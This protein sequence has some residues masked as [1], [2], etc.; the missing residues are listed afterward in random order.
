[1]SRA[2]SV[3]RPAI[4]GFLRTS[5]ENVRK[6]SQTVH[7]DMFWHSEGLRPHGG[8]LRGD[9]LILAT[10]IPYSSVNIKTECCPVVAFVFNAQQTV[11]KRSNCTLGAFRDVGCP[12]GGDMRT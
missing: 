3:S 2:H 4:S 8:G 11:P 5:P 6:P 9:F 12:S 1:M 10:I 7:F